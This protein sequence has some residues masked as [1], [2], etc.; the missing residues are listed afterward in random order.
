MNVSLTARYFPYQLDFTFE[1]G[2]SRGILKKKISWFFILTDSRHPDLAGWGEAGPLPGL[3]PESNSDLPEVFRKIAEHI[4]GLKLP[5]SEAACLRLAAELCDIQY[6]SVRFA[7]ESALLDLLHGGRREVI[8]GNF[9]TG[10]EHIPINGL[11]WMGDE[12][13]MKEQFDHKFDDSYSCFKM[14]IGAIDFEKELSTLAYIRSRTEAIL[15]VDANGAFTRND[16]FEKLERLSL[17]NL[18]SIEQPVMAGQWDLMADVC[19]ESPIPVALDEELIGLDNEEERREMLRTVRPSY[20]ILK[21]TLLGGIASTRNWIQL[22]EEFG[23]GWWMTSALESNIGLNIICQLTAAEGYTGH[24][25]LGTGQL[26]HN[27]IDSPLEV[28]GG[29]I[30]Y[31]PGKRWKLPILNSDEKDNRR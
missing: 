14:K 5:E 29:F 25:G 19:R 16:V 11:I 1:A 3:S 10:S 13:F 4:H 15:R 30:S 22:A 17:F 31:I 6:P 12:D 26:Y 21:P 2:T 20:I 24:Q 8:P 28:A 23:I 9:F 7:L 27:N 18:H